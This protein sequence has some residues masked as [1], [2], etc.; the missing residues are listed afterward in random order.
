[1]S[2][3]RIVAID[4]LRTLA[5]ILM[6]VFH[7]AFDLQTMYGW[8]IDVFRGGWDV[9][10]LLTATIFIGIAGITTH[11]TTHPYKRTLTIA[12]AAALVTAATYMWDPETYVRFGILH[13]I[14]LTV[15]LLELLK[16]LRALTVPLGILII[17]AGNLFAGTTVHTSLLLPLGF[18]PPFFATLDYYPLLP[19]FGVALIG[20]G[21]GFTSVIRMRNNPSPI[22]RLLTLPGRHTLL[23]YLLHQPVI[24]GML[25][26]IL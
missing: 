1:M 25:S 6:I 11:L 20:Y 26:F 16:P 3:Q 10:R 12:A 19:W 8:D 4:L 22:I 17:V 18:P 15:L 7:I 5:I 24:I 23:I 21:F 9:L 14:A 2:T 13:C